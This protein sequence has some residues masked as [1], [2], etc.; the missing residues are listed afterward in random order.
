[1]DPFFPDMC[2][3]YDSDDDVEFVA[4]YY[5]P[6][7]KTIGDDDCYIIEEDPIKIELD[8]EKEE[9]EMED[10]NCEIDRLIVDFE[11]NN[12]TLAKIIEEITSDEKTRKRTYD[13]VVETIEEDI[14]ESLLD[15]C[16]EP[17]YKKMR[18][19]EIYNAIDIL[20]E[21]QETKVDE[22]DVEKMLEDL[23]NMYS[24][25]TESNFYDEQDVDI[26]ALFD[27]NS[28]HLENEEEQYCSDDIDIAMNALFS[29]IQSKSSLSESNLDDEDE[30]QSEE[31]TTLNE[32]YKVSDSFEEPP[33]VDDSWCITGNIESKKKT[34]TLCR[35]MSNRLKI[36]YSNQNV[37]QEI[38]SFK[39]DETS[40]ATNYQ[41]FVITG[42]SNYN[43]DKFSFKTV[44][45]DNL[46]F[47]N[48]MM[49]NRNPKSKYVC[50]YSKSED[51]VFKKSVNDSHIFKIKKSDDRLFNYII[52]QKKHLDKLV[53]LSKDYEMEYI[54]AYG[55][56]KHKFAK[57]S[58]ISSFIIE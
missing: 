52:V 32:L 53:F 51:L 23:I 21:E 31:S 5:D 25:T 4:E 30:T 13:D 39:K 1:M 54:K 26:E 22:P 7:L 35:I 15:M 56:V 16:E 41:K 2:A 12:L 57:L 24:E 48:K 18:Y 55:S 47:K 46:L 36:Y 29:E 8:L 43:G 49:M 28:E 50:F 27:E 3:L 14:I 38:I 11:T 37:L 33:K 17:Q 44:I 40:E 6:L 45:L 58:N 34:S 19:E 20:T 10:L 42:G 9:K